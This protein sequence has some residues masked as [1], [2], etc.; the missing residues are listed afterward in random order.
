MKTYKVF[1]DG[2]PCSEYQITGFDRDAFPSLDEAN[3]FAYDWVLGGMYPD[4]EIILERARKFPLQL[5]VGM[6][7]SWCE[8]PIVM[9]IR[10]VEDPEE[11]LELLL[12]TRNQD[13][14]QNVWNSLKDE[15]VHFTLFR[16]AKECYYKEIAQEAFN[17]LI[18]KCHN[19]YIYDLAM[20]AGRKSIA[21]E[22]W[23]LLKISEVSSESLI[24]F[25][26]RGKWL[27]I[28]K[29]AWEVLKSRG[30]DTNQLQDIA[31]DTKFQHVCDE[32]NVLLKYKNL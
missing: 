20:D 17:T 6:D 24:Q 23:D 11:L 28:A 18:L 26:I 29:S 31:K 13:V 30:L 2:K 4:K 32:A 3:I 25:L 12:E 19:S 1:Q 27:T 21:E 10:A 5:G 14:A 8:V 22:A 7:L 15:A 9:E 16:I